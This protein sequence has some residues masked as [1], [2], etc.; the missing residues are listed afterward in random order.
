MP[1]RSRRPDDVRTWLGARPSLDDLRETFPHEWE[2]VDRELNAVVDTGDPAALKS[3]V[4]GLAKPAPTPGGRRGRPTRSGIDAALAAQV[5]RAMAAE[6]IRNLSVRAASGVKTGRV[7]FN[8]FN[9]WIAQRLLFEHGLVRKPVSMGWFRLLWPLLWQRRRLMPLVEPQGIYCFY[10]GALVRR[11]AGLIDGRRALEVAAGDGT[12]SRFLRAEGVA[13]TATD[14][15][16]WSAV[17]FPE[18][19]E[20]LGAAQAVKQY[21]PEVVICS[22]PPAGNDFEAAIF[23]A[24]SV[25]LYVVIGSAHELGAGNPRAYASQ[26]TFELRLDESLSKLV[27]PPDLNSVIRIFERRPIA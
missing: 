6:A 16:S 18:D 10:S 17:A 14:D 20:K 8:L 3:Y 23:A 27:V 22:W 15:H 7:R 25:Q 19:V 1:P 5:R 21:E 4:A 2:Q 9:G 13:I 24:P 11:L 12:L 26:G